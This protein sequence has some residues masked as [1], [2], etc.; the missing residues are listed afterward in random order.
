MFKKRKK[1]DIGEAVILA[2]KKIGPIHIMPGDTLEMSITMEDE[3]VRREE[4]VIVHEMKTQV[5]VDEAI[6]FENDN[7]LG[8]ALKKVKK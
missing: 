5:T 1:I 4:K 2:Q 3:R 7:Y 8:G 6:I